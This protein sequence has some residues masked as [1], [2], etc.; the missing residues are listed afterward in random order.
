MISNLFQR[1]LRIRD[2]PVIE[3]F[4]QPHKRFG[5]RFVYDVILTQ[6]IELVSAL[7][8]V[9]PREMIRDFLKVECLAA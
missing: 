7:I 3:G 4:N 5:D 1:D 2:A 9:S 6:S 8:Q